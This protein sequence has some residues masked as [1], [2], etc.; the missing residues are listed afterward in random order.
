MPPAAAPPENRWQRLMRKLLYGHDVD[1]NVKAKARLGL[2]ILAFAG[3]YCVIALRLVMF[4]A[5]S[6]GHGARRSVGQDA[7]ATARPDILDRNGRVL[8]TDVKTPSLFAEPRK[9]I[10]VDEAEELLTA[11]LPDLDAT[12]LRDRL[13][14]KRGFVWLKR[15]ITP[16]QQQRDSP[17]RHSRRRLS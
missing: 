15:E 13:S 17:A 9:L 10:D 11:V 4:A 14:S 1:R 8:A 16:K 5:V 12:E 6:D 7:V 3:I 2:A